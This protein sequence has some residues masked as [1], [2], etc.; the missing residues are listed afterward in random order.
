MRFGNTSMLTTQGFKNKMMGHS[1]EE[2]LQHFQIFVPASWVSS[3]SRLGVW[4]IRSLSWECRV[5]SGTLHTLNGMPIHHGASH[6]LIYMLSKFRVISPTI[7]TNLVL[8]VPPENLEE[9]QAVS[10]L[11]FP[12]FRFIPALTLLTLWICLLHCCYPVLWSRLGTW[13][14]WNCM[15]LPP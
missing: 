9:T 2:N 8:E 4:W 5:W 12:V 1:K 15:G 10:C 11:T 6:T 7:D 3:L 13:L 14:H